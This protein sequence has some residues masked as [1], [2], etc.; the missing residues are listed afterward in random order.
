M[1]PRLRAQEV[2]KVGQL[3]EVDRGMTYVGVEDTRQQEQWQQHVMAPME[4]LPQDL[5][6]PHAH[7]TKQSP[8][9]T[10]GWHGSA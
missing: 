5:Q 8:P 1:L 4:Q 10:A 7:T 3:Q 9:E 6:K 2:L